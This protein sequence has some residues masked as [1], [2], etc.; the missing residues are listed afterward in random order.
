MTRPEP[1]RTLTAPR[2]PSLAA[3]PLLAALLSCATEQPPETTEE[4][5]SAAI[6]LPSCES[7]CSPTKSCNTACSVRDSQ[8]PVGTFCFVYMNGICDGKEELVTN[9][10]SDPPL[11]PGSTGGAYHEPF[12]CGAP[13]EH[14]IVLWEHANFQ[15]RCIHVDAARYHWPNDMYVG[16]IQDA[17]SNVFFND[18]LTSLATGSMVSLEIFDH[19]NFGR[20]FGKYGPGRRIDNVGAIAND[21]VSSFIIRITGRKPPRV[22]PGGTP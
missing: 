3:A 4:H 20:S 11:P 10:G 21:K 17:G 15:G 6:T 2:R 16:W 1:I 22:L 18:T 14:E 19:A 8:G 12:V 13:R 7:Q 9:L 5:A